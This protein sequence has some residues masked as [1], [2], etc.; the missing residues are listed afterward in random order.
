MSYSCIFQLGLMLSPPHV[1]CSNTF[2]SLHTRSSDHGPDM[3]VP[4][5]QCPFSTK[6]GIR[7]QLLTGTGSIR[8]I[9]I[10]FLFTGILNDFMLKI[11]IQLIY[12][13]TFAALSNPLAVFT[14]CKDD[15]YNFIFSPLIFCRLNS[16]VYEGHRGKLLLF[17][18]V[19]ICSIY[20]RSFFFFLSIFRN[21]LFLLMT[22]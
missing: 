19:V 9:G 3:C 6:A 1:T 12:K 21:S 13:M 10:F 8:P 2:M 7:L 22:A 15:V 11:A 17:G 16:G 5:L 4:M 18:F 14:N 20:S